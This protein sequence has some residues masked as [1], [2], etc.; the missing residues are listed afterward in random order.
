MKDSDDK[1]CAIVALTAFT[2]QSNIEKCESLGM[3]AVL[4]KPAVPKKVVETV[5]KYCDLNQVI[6]RPE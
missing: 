3:K 4:N 6:F 2:N 1:R 5:E